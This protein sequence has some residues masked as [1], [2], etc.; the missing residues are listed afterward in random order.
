MNFG[1][2]ADMSNAVYNLNG[3]VIGYNPY[4]D[5]YV[6]MTGYDPVGFNKLNPGNIWNNVAYKELRSS[7]KYHWIGAKFS[8]K[9]LFAQKINLKSLTTSVNGAMIGLNQAALSYEW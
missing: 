2:K 7:V 1:L 9:D 3:G 8:K 4:G 5:G 6:D